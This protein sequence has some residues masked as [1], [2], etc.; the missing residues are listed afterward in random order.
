M[1]TLLWRYITFSGWPMGGPD[2]IDNTVCVC[3]N[4]HRELH[5]GKRAGLL[6]DQ[7][8]RLR[9]GNGYADVK[10]LY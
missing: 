1:A 6:R 9:L 4:H 10:S 2:T 5:F 7:L 8:E 3:P